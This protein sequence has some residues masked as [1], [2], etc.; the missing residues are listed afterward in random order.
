MNI[1]LQLLA[2]SSGQGRNFYNTKRQYQ[3][4]QQ[5]SPIFNPLIFRSELFLAKIIPL[6]VKKEAFTSYVRSQPLSTYPFIYYEAICSRQSE[7]QQKNKLI[8][9]M[10][11]RLNKLTQLVEVL[12][13]QIQNS[14]EKTTTTTTTTESSVDSRANEILVTH[15]STTAAVTAVE[16]QITTTTTTAI[17]QSFTPT[18]IE[19]TNLNENVQKN[20][21]QCEGVTCPE[22]TAFCQIARNSVAPLHKVVKVSIYCVSNDDSIL[23]EDHREVENPDGGIVNISQTLGHQS[24]NAN[25]EL[26]NPIKEKIED[27][28]T[29]M[30]AIRDKNIADM[31]EKMKNMFNNFPITT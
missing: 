3:Q 1:V 28:L 22:D 7:I 16:E 18:T 13:S 11:E 17:E 21:I 19:S 10:D 30:Q 23:D 29:K 15:K 27:E 5:Q 12:Q 25:N 26:M 24:N 20:V 6:N 14:N 8:E 9:A 4:Q 31:N 2:L